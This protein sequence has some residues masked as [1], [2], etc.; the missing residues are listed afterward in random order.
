MIPADI[1]EES[2]FGLLDNF[3]VSV[4]SLQSH[5]LPPESCFF[6]PEGGQ[7]CPSTALYEAHFLTFGGE[8][9]KSHFLLGFTNIVYAFLV[10]SELVSA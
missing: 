3:I 10:T 8:L 4:G 5:C 7:I 6:A 1:P 9:K 2:Y